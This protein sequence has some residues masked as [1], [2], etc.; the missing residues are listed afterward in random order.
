MTR[1]LHTLLLLLIGTGHDAFYLPS[2]NTIVSRHLSTTLLSASTLDA[3]DAISTTIEPTNIPQEIPSKKEEPEFNW[4][5]AWYPLVPAEFLDPSKPHNFK[6]LGMDLCLWN[7]GAESDSFQAKQKK[8]SGLARL[9]GKKKSITPLGNWNAFEDKCPHRKVPLSEGRVE[10]DGTLLCS[11]HG[12]RFDGDGS[13]VTIPQESN[14]TRMENIRANPKSQCNAFP[15][16]IVKGLIWVWPENGPDAVLESELTPV[17]AMDPL[18]DET[19]TQIPE[20]NLFLGSWNFRELPYGADYFLEN[21]V[22]PAHVPV[23]HH[24]VVGDRYVDPQPLNVS[25]QKSLTKDGF[26][27]KVQSVNST[28]EFVAPALVKIDGDPSTARQC[29]ELYVSPSRPGFCNHVGRLNIVKNKDGSLPTAFKMFTQPIPIWANHLLAAKFLNQ[30]ALFLHA[31]E[32]DFH[33]PGGKYKTSLSADA[34]GI[35]AL[36]DNDDYKKLVYTPTDADVGV[37]LFRD[38][39]KKKAGGM[40]PFRGERGMP[41]KDTAVVFDQWNSHTKHCQYCMDA[42]HN[43]RKIRL[44]TAVMAIVC[45]IWR[46]GKIVTAASVGIFGGASYLS[47][48]IIKAFH[49][50]EFSHAEND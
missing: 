10:S 3:T 37:I 32:R 22:D 28:T 2:T 24:N 12:W 25:T 47:H 13:C 7:D 30:D 23:S 27:I 1:Q 38:W 17:P 34:D 39:L 20:E 14:P 4:Y 50:Q 48:K 21:V 29:L 33:A 42:Y 49:Q 35:A 16:K 43:T 9:F 6:L 19:G 41:P 26:E 36:E 15:V 8:P 45:G 5:K 18:T 44:A 11:Y 31:Q 46:P 40:I